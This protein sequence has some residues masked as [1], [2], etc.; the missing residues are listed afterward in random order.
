M[1]HVESSEKPNTLLTDR[2]TDGLLIDL[3]QVCR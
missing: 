1:T 3:Y 2:Q